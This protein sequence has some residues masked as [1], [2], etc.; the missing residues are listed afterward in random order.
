MIKKAHIFLIASLLTLAP[1][2]ALAEVTD[3][4]SLM[5]V[6]ID[7][8][9]SFMVFLYILALTAFFWGIALFILNTDDEK[10]REEGKK[11]MFWSLIAL[12]VMLTVWGIVGIL[13]NT[14]GV[15]TT[16]IPQLPGGKA[17]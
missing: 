15:G 14:F 3:F 13:V 8:L 2:F 17:A 6:F 4:K 16:I 12:F 5:Q 10:K 7:I 9:G 11:W 1:S